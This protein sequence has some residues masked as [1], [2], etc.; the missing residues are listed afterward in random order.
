MSTYRWK[1]PGAQD[2]HLTFTFCGRCGI[3][4]YAQGDLEWLGG[5]FHAISVPALDLSPE[6]LA[7]IPV[8][9]VNGREG[10]YEEAPAH[11]EAM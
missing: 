7:A 8:R 6:Q 2:S 11:P 9:Y 3:R 4:T 1:P 10:R 5:I